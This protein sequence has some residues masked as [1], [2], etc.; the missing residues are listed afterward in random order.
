MLYEYELLFFLDENKIMKL[1][2]SLLSSLTVIMKR[3][4]TSP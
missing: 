4:L 3:K 1:T 2:F